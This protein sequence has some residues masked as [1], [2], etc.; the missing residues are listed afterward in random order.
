M[1]AGREKAGKPGIALTAVII[2]IMLSA[3]GDSYPANPYSPSEDIKPWQDVLS[4]DSDYPANVYLTENV[5]FTPG[6]VGI[7][8]RDSSS[9]YY[10]ADGKPVDDTKNGACGPPEGTAAINSSNTTAMTVLGNGGSAVWRF[11]PKWVIINGSG[12]DFITFSNHNILYGVPDDSWNEL[13]HVYVSE[14]NLNWYKCKTETY[15]ANEAPLTANDGYI[16]ASVS[17][18]HGNYHS[19][20]NFREEV[21]AESLGSSSGRYEPV[22]ASSGKAV[23]ISRYF[24]PSDPYLGPYLGGDRFDLADFIHTETGEAWPSGGKMKYLKLIDAPEALD[25]QDWNPD[26]MTGARIMSA[27]GIN[28]E[29][30][31]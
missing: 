30:S 28:V 2:L 14:D 26:W 3:C 9:P 18:M 1:A 25:G 21:E 13:A 22:I 20:A 23:M 29:P 10:G 31:N 7:A 8:R 16:W 19:W 5:E 24:E 27:M 17:G 15:T 6:L 11:D 4:S 12:D